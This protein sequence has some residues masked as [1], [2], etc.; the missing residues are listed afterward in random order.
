[1]RLIVQLI[2]QLIVIAAITLIATSAYVMID[3][4]KNVEAETVATA[5]RVAFELENLFWREILWRGSMRRDKV[6]PVPNWESLSTLKLVSPGVCLAF[7]PAGDEPRQLCSRLEGVGAS[8]PEWFA[9][10]YREVF[11]PERPVARQ[12]TVRA[13]ETG[14]V[15]AIANADAAVRQAWGQISVVLGVAASMAAAICLLA[16]MAIARA[17]APTQ[18]I[19]EGLRRLQDGNYRRPIAYQA[20]EFGLIAE[21]ANDLAERLAQTAAERTALTKRLFEVQEEERRALARDLHDEFGQCLTATLAFAASIEAGA[22][23]RPDLAEDAR[24]ISGVAKRMMTT[25]REALARLRSQDLEELGLEACLV[26]LVAGWNAR[27]QSRAKVHL[28]LAGNLKALPRAVSISVYRIAQECLTNAMRHGR[29]SD[30]RLSIE[31]GRSSDG[32]IAMTVEDDG[33]GDPASVKASAGHGILGMRE[34]IAAL[35]GSLSIGRSA[36]GL[37]IAARIPLSPPG[38]TAPPGLATA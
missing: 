22:L 33:G 14:I 15:V 3:A 26:Q 16:A 12:L 17:L 1:M 35:G 36:H 4:H 38:G 30:I 9:R 7:A 19:I 10:A 27:P 6:L 25:L 18:T 34:R 2:A 5:D 23:D 37:L 8:A 24:S 11:G 28:D 31:S 13:P 21:A 32:Q 29:P 20:A